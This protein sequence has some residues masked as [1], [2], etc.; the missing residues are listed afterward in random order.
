MYLLESV[1]GVT[2]V[3]SFGAILLLFLVSIANNSLLQSSF[4]RSSY[5]IVIY[6]SLKL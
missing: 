4:H 6:F 5:I 1:E 3:M 2:G